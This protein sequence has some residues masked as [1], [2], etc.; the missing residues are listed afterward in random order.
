MNKTKLL[1]YGDSPTCSTGFGNVSKNILAQLQETG[2]YEISILG[3]NFYGNPDE[4]KKFPEYTIYPAGVNNQSD[5]YGRQLLLDL[6]R[7]KNHNFDVL[8]T[9]QDTFIMATVGESIKKLRDGFIKEV[10]GKKI[11]QKGRNFKWVYYYPIDAVPEKEWIEKSVKFADVAVP[12]THYAKK[13]SEQVVERDYKVIYHGVDTKTFY[14]ME[15]E[16]KDAFAEE[17]FKENKL[18]GSFLIVNVNRNQERKGFLYTLLAFKLFRSIVPNSVLYTH[19]DVKN[20]RGGNL[21]KVAARLG[22]TENWLYPNPDTY[23][24]GYSFPASYLN[25]IY[26]LADLNISTTLGEGW[27]LSVSE[28]MA[29]KTLNVLPDNTSLTEILSDK[30]GLLYK[31]GNPPTQIVMNGPLDNSLIRPMPNV[32][33]MVEKM[34]WAYSHPDATKEII[35][36][37]YHWVQEN[38]LWEN[39]G[40][41]WDELISKIVKR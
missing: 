29:C 27:G 13:K 9:L 22:I 38:I 34:L 16:E 35:E 23:Q 17:F 5:V 12:Y 36:N 1:F 31:S 25:G 7:D 40:S 33:D 2:K 28:A 37:A 10:D 26:N 21:L 3:I 4:S 6:L 18:K 20:D 8:F 39:I 19:C 15:K 24:K 14:P 41:Q 32:E 11:F 30:K